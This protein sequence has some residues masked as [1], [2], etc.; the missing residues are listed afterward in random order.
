LRM[1]IAGNDTYYADDGY[2]DLIEHTTGAGN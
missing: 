2:R 1:A